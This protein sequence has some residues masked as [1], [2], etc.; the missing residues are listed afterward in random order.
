VASEN[1]EALTVDSAAQQLLT[2]FESEP[3]EAPPEPSEEETP[4]EAEVQ[5]EA[6]EPEPSEPAGDGDDAEPVSKTGDPLPDTGV[7]KEVTVST[8][9]ELA[10]ATETDMDFLYGL[11]LKSESGTEYT[12]GEAKDLLQNHESIKAQLETV[13]IS[14]QALETERSQS[15]QQFGTQLQ[16]LAGLIQSVETQLTEDEGS[17]DMKQLRQDDPAEFSIRQQ[18]I[19]DRKGAIQQVRSQ[20]SQLYSQQRQVAQ[21]AI[22][23]QK[24]EYLAQER[25]KLAQAIPE[26]SD[27]EVAKAENQ[28]IAGFLSGIG[29]TDDEISNCADHRMVVLARKAMNGNVAEL[30]IDPAK[31]R[32]AKLP[33]LVKSGTPPPKEAAEKQKIK[34]LKGRAK[35]SGKV[36]DAANL[37]LQDIIGAN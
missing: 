34:A 7:E 11:K 20:A 16:Q 31:K 26:W 13:A 17:D 19:R 21:T 37:I 32:V 22:D 36:E 1:T 24:S 18:E 28:Q 35:E 10:E 27:P 2:G 12:L 3:E 14:K 5:T 23:T 15:Q 29:F 25:V 6:S 9:S 30:A 4:P 8:L 33:L